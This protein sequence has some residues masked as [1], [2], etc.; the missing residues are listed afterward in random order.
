M[1]IYSN[2][3]QG[4]FLVLYVLRELSGACTKRE[5]LQFIEDRKLYEITRHDLPPYPGQNEPKYHTLLCWARKDAVE[6]D[7]MLDI[8]QRD[9]WQLTRAGRELLERITEHFRKG[10]LSVRECYLWTPIFKKQIDPTYEPSPADRI[11]PEDALD[12]I[13]GSL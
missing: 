2:R 3:V 9:A 11:R 12:A 5:V 6:R 1:K 7:W 13:L 4:V 10:D 8:D